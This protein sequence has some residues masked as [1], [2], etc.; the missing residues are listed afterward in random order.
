MKRLIITLAVIAAIIMPTLLYPL[1]GIHIPCTIGETVEDPSY[2]VYWAA[3]RYHGIY[4][5]FYARGTWWFERDGHII[6][7]RGRRKS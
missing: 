1:P 5:S 6:E 7:Y 2:P 3:R 4:D